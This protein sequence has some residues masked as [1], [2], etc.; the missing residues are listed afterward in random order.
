MQCLIQYGLITWS[1]QYFYLD[2]YSA[3]RSLC[4]VCFSSRAGSTFNSRLIDAICDIVP[5]NKLGILHG[6]Q[7]QAE[8]ACE[9]NMVLIHIYSKTI[10]TSPPSTVQSYTVYT[11]SSSAGH[12][13]LHSKCCSLALL[14][15]LSSFC[16][17]ILRKE[18]LMNLPTLWVGTVSPN[19]C[20]Q[21][22]KSITG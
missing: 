1:S 20:Q 13:S 21:I 17:L 14:L 9:K 12:W 6:F 10:S 15:S 22:M 19:H 8:Y 18:L 5:R 16:R 3:S 7:L 4:R 11:H 2:M